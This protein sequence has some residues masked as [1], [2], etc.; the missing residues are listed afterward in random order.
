[1]LYLIANLLL[2]FSFLTCMLAFWKGGRAEVIGAA[3]I[4]A[5]LVATMANEALVHGQLTSL[6]IDGV[7]A[8]VLLAAAL[9]FASLWL[10]GVMLL[11]AA[12]FATQA[13]YLVLERPRDDLHVVLNNTVWFAISV[14]LA[15]GTISTW[16]SRRR[17]LRT[18]QPEPRSAIDRLATR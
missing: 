13:Y 1:M 14:C 2:V 10:G 3:I 12:Q 7:T 8:V 5:N 15:A 17:D 6:A 16:M 11:Y 18:S 4:L 9:R